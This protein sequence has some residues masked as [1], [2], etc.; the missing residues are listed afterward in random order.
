MGR[1]RRHPRVRRRADQSATTTALLLERCA[2]G[3]TL[4]GES[5]GGTGRRHRRA[6][7]PAVAR[8]GGPRARSAHSSR[9]ATTGQTVSSASWQRDEVTGSIPALARDGADL[10]RSLPATASDGALA[11]HRPPRRERPGRRS[12]S[13]G[14]SSTPSPSSA[15]RPTTRSS[16]TS[17]ARTAWSPTRWRSPPAWRACSGLDAERLL[18]W[19]FAVLRR[20]VGGL[21]LDARGRRAGSGP[22]RR[23]PA[24]SRRGPGPR[25]RAGRVWVARRATRISMTTSGS[26]PLIAA[27][28]EVRRRDQLDRR[29]DLLAPQP[30]RLLAAPSSP[31]KGAVPRTAAA[32]RSPIT[33]SPSRASMLAKCPCSVARICIGARPPASKRRW[34]TRSAVRGSPRSMASVSA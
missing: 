3:T 23:E 33:S 29:G 15:T 1:R 30:A 25:L 4:V 16:I 11:L 32:S 18:L 19:L 13:H 20:P 14:W 34:S 31:T 28:V 26:S 22:K 17:T 6:A 10:F 7:P 27:A 9:C 12:G 21:P 2:P 24:R 5:R 8:P